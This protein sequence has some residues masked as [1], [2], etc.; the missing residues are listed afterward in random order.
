[1]IEDRVGT[2]PI[3]TAVRGT[4][5]VVDAATGLLVTAKHV[6]EKCQASALRVRSVYTVAGDYALGLVNSVSAI[7]EHPSMDLAILRISRQGTKRRQPA[8]DL[9]FDAEV[10]DRIAI[11]GYGQGTDLVFCDDILGTGSPK[12]IT[13][14][15]F[16]GDVAA[17]VPE[18]GR[19]VELVVYGAS[20]FPGHSGG[21]VLSL[22]SDS[23]VAIHLR[24]AAN[25][26][27]YGLP[28]KRC[29][30][31]LRDVQAGTI[32]STS[33]PTPRAST[34][35]ALSQFID[36]E[37]KASSKVAEA[38]GEPPDVQA[39]LMAALELEDPTDLLEWDWEDD[40]GRTTE[41][42]VAY[43]QSSPRAPAS[44]LIGTVSVDESVVPEG[45]PRKLEEVRLKA[46]GEIWEIHKNDA[47]PRPSN[48]HAHNVESGLKLDLSTGELYRKTTMV[49]RVTKKDLG[50]IRDLAEAKAIALPPLLI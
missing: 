12:S 1:M 4:A 45:V 33:A 14:I 3:G 9:A 20:T 21:P 42:A 37:N 30:Q 5:F 36:W 43:L 26:V 34:T 11:V 44:T 29:S 16:Q 10:G 40:A 7:Y 19:P 17:I 32:S 41:S 22:E 23:V 31:F 39:A 48:P 6:V 47:D 8:L 2:A 27:G 28:L 49:G 25:Q 13:P 50:K 18:D 35:D 24:S 46:A 38:G 15:C